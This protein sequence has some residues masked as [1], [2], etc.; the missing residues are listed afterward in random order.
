MM[1]TSAKIKKLCAIKKKFYFRRILCG[2]G[3]GDRYLADEV[4]REYQA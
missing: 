1:N 4:I 3:S 2:I